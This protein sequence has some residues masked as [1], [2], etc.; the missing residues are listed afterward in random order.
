M[1]TKN[2]K[3]ISV[4]MAAYEAEKYI[5]ES[6][7]SIREQTW[8][9][10]ELV[11]C[12]DASSDGT[13]EI[14]LRYAEQDERITVLRNDRNLGAAATRN[15]CIQGSRGDYIAVQDGDDVS[16]PDRLAVLM[17]RMERGGCD[18]VSSA[19]Y[20]FDEGGRY[21]TD[22]PRE[23]YPGKGSFL[24]GL[25]FCH[26]A[27]LF[28]RACLDAVQGYRV[29]PETARNEDYDLFMRLYAAGYKGCNVQEVL[30]GYRV[31]EAA[32]RRRTFR[33]RISE[34]RVRA[35]G[36]RRLGILF[37][38]GWLYV[39][40]PIAAHLYWRVRPAGQGRGTGL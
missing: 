18:F 24:S 13:Y 12:D 15:R 7:E 30:Y 2:G 11:I 37:P 10:W 29:S 8:P 21:R 31:D 19:H 34:C 36:F 5:A 28:T 16:E 40:R 17:A 33:A 39:L 1:E 22:V 35:Y 25:P 38:L 6:I 27:T 14:L 3:L 26:A 20:L 23:E 32:L 4:I 9:Q